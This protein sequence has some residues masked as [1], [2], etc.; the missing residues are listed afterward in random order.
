MNELVDAGC[1]FRLFPNDVFVVHVDHADIALFAKPLLH[2]RQF[3]QKQLCH[4][5]ITD[6]T[7][8]LAKPVEH[9]LLGAKHL[10]HVALHE[11]NLVLMFRGEIVEKPGDHLAC[12]PMDFGQP[13]RIAF[14]F[15]HAF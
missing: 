12:L 11:N 4:L 15:F 5:L 1:R 14:D 6:R 7:A 9:L 10:F 2:V 8:R 13:A 3:V